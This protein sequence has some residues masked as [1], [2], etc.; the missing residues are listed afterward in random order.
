MIRRDSLPI[1]QPSQPIVSIPFPQ[2]W[3]M[4]YRFF[5]SASFMTFLTIFC[6][7]I[8]NARTTRSLTQLAQRLPP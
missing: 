5:F 6:S 3:P 7:S 2:K 4:I 1:L 8:R